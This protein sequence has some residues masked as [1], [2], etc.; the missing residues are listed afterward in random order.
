EVSHR[1]DLKDELMLLGWGDYFMRTFHEC[2][3]SAQ[4]ENMPNIH[5]NAKG[6]FLGML[7][8]EENIFLPSKGGPQSLRWKSFLATPLLPKGKE[9]KFSG[10]EEIGDNTDLLGQ[11]IDA[12]AHH[13]VIDSMGEFLFADIQGSM[14][15]GNNTVVLFDPQAH[16]FDKVSGHWD[17]GG[18]AIK[19]FL[20]GHK[21]NS[22]CHQLHIDTLKVTVPPSPSSSSMNPT[23]DSP[24]FL[25][26]SSPQ[27]PDDTT[28]TP[29]VNKPVKGPFRP[30]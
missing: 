11:W 23:K 26:S 7:I 25:P 10:N 28:E 1:E 15:Y 9:V 14:V 30:W 20:A 19:S 17:K 29:K 24:L 18:G 16:T 3:R 5:W 22:V 2:V 27:A 13:T 4:V 8:E 12:F 21:C 6:A